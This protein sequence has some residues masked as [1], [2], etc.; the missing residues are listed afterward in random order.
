MKFDPRLKTKNAV[1]GGFTIQWR[2]GLQSKC[3]SLERD[4]RWWRCMVANSQ[5]IPLLSQ[6]KAAACHDLK[7]FDRLHV[8]L[9]DLTIAVTFVG[10]PAHYQIPRFE[11]R[12]RQLG[13]E[14]PTFDKHCKPPFK[15]I[16]TRS[17]KCKRRGQKVLTE[18]S[19][20]LGGGEQTST[21]FHPTFSR[22]GV[23]VGDE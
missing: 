7:C 3:E 11:I 17:P 1:Q 5:P 6:I 21:L 9:R 13:C 16:F 22:H 23:D 4:P 2:E 20:K 10:G 12:T 8:T 18:N 15:M 19:K 14:N